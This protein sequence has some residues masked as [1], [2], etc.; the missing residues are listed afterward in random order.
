MSDVSYVAAFGGGL[1]SFLSP[2]VLPIVPGYLSVV[3]GLS[4]AELREGSGDHL[5]RIAVFTGLF[6]LGFTVVFVLLG[7]AASTAGR[8]LF[9]NQETLTRIAGVVVVLMALYLIGS[10]VLKRPGLYQ[11]FR[12]HPRVERLGPWGI[13]LTGAAFGLG[14]SPCL[15]PVLASVLGVA[16]TQTSARALTLLVVYSLG[17]GV[18]FLATGLLFG[19]LG[20]ALGWFKRHS[21]AI[22]MVSAVVLGIFGVVLM[23]DALPRVTAELSKL[24][25]RFGLGRLIELG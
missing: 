4:A 8:S 9:R 18:P 22:T 7:L 5:R 16:A 12:F 25:D 24:L 11:E 13:P 2:C 14:W 6:V 3:T 1:V 17:L 23:F 20:G 21:V 10:Q 15:G 19:R